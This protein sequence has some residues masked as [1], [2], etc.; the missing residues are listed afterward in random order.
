MQNL[1]KTIADLGVLVQR[2]EE[3]ARKNQ[4]P[5]GVYNAS[6]VEDEMEFLR[7]TR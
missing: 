3:N 4:E 7:R 6:E 2:A 1:D 5:T